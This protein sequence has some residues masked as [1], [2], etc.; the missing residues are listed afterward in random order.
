MSESSTTSQEIA[1]MTKLFTR[2]AKLRQLLQSVPPVIDTVYVADDGNPDSEDRDVYTIATDA[3][4]DL[5]VID[6]PFDAGLGRGRKEI[7]DR[8]DEEYLL[9]LDSDMEVPANVNLLIDALEAAPSFGGI[10]GLPREFGE[11][12]GLC[13]DLR[14][15]TR[16]DNTYLIRDFNNRP[17]ETYSGVDIRPFDF[18]P[19]A[20]LFRRKCLEDYCWDPAYVI[21]REHID[22]YVGHWKKTDWRF[23]VAPT[24]EIPHYP[25]GSDSYMA[26]RHNMMK[27]Q[28][29]KKYFRKKWGYDAVIHENDWL[30]IGSDNPFRPLPSPPLPLSAKARAK[31]ARQ[32]FEGAFHRVF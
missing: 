22:F 31:R 19:N 15:E 13:H 24:V 26:N 16:K 23:G 25:G 20:A 7:V 28:R 3:S 17:I 6:L 2:T 11:V 21:A 1:L 12:S 5:E 14:E 29:S 9:L 8:A 10:A 4:Y 27:K 32:I 18:I 30:G